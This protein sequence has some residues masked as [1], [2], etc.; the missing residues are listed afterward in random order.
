MSTYHKKITATMATGAS[1][2]TAVNIEG[3]D[4]MSLMIPT[5][6]IGAT[7]ANLDITLQVAN[8]STDTF[9]DLWQISDSGSIQVKATA[10]AGSVIIAVPRPVSEINYARIKADVAC[11]KNLQCEFLVASNGPI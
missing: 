2:T 4:S 10:T 7:S 1:Y 3:F 11:T 8:G 5:C 6:V 9:R